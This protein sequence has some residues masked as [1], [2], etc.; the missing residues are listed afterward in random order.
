MLVTGF[1]IVLLFKFQYIQIDDVLE[2]GANIHTLV[3][4]EYVRHFNITSQNL[5]WLC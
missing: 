1:C 5:Q 3:S 4:A 2:I